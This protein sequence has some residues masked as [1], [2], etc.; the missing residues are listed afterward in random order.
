MKIEW[1]QEENKVFTEYHGQMIY[2]I[3]PEDFKLSETHKDTINLLNIVLFAQFNKE[4]YEYE[5]EMREPRKKVGISMSTGVDSTAVML[6]MPEDSICSYMKR[7]FPGMLIHDNAMKFIEESDREISVVKSNHEI[8]RTFHGF[9]VG[10]ST[11]LSCMAHL[12]LLADYYKI[13]NLCAGTV[14][15]NGYLTRGHLYRDYKDTWNWKHWSK[16][17][18]DNGFNLVLTTIGTSEIVTSKIVEQ[19]EYKNLAQSCLRK[20]GGCMNCYKC[21]RKGLLTNRII[22]MDRES[23]IFMSKNP[24]K[25]AAS[26]LYALQKNNLR[27]KIVEKYLDVD[28]SFLERYNPVYIEDVIPKELMENLIKRLEF[29]GIEPMNEQDIK[30]MKELNLNEIN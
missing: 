20:F 27:P 28:F 30:K 2:F 11:D 5:T 13:G 19:S 3:V 18:K 10:F 8:I 15:E 24:P 6:L 21:Y 26:I 9:G 7:D 23:E 1:K 25:M 22:P 17:F 16:I 29:Y 14:L 12:I 4:L